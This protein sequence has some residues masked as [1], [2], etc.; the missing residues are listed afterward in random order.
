MKKGL[1]YLV[2]FMFLCFPLFA[3][4]TVTEEREQYLVD[5]PSVVLLVKK[6][7]ALY[8]EGK[9]VEARDMYE[10]LLKEN[11][12]GPLSKKDIQKKY[13]DFNMNIL[14]S[15]I[16]TTDSFI[17]TVENGDA[18]Y[19]I[20]KKFN[21]TV[22][23]LQKANGLSGSNIYVG[24]KLKIIKSEFSV[25][26][27][28]SDN[29]LKLKLG[30]R[31]MKTYHVATGKNNCTPVGTFKITDKL[32][33]PTWYHAGAVVPPESEENILGTRWMGFDLKGYGIHGTTIPDSIGTQDTAG[34]V[35]MYNHEVEELYAIVPSGTKVVIVD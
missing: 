27:D 17:Y 22:E 6:A 9:L 20:A 24:D 29:I 3:Q 5:A 34:C 8:S 2:V 23:L 21:T 7:D 14:F 30:E 26:V 11:D 12:F 16:V 15:R 10:G 4:E 31:L 13:E 28:K 19:K 35:R 1:L 33:N 18:L 32:P 25:Y